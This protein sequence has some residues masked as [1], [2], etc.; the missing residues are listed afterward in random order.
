MQWVL[1]LEMQMEQPSGG[2]AL[3]FLML[4]LYTR[5]TILD[6]AALCLVSAQLDR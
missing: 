2:R 3:M 5:L 4:A 1:G 6:V